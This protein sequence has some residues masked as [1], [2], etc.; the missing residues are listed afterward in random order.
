[1]PNS[2]MKRIETKSLTG[3]QMFQYSKYGYILAPDGFTK[4][5]PSENAGTENDTDETDFAKELE[6]QTEENKINNF[7]EQQNDNYYE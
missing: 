6:L 3:Y 5:Y 7:F 2:I 4:I 1:M